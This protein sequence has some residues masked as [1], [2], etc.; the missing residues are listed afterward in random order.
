M[1]KK[2]ASHSYTPLSLQD[3]NESDKVGTTSDKLSRGQEIESP[4]SD[5]RRA[6]MSDENSSSSF[7][8]DSIDSL[9]QRRH[10]SRFRDISRFGV[11]TIFNSTY[12]NR[13]RIRYLVVTC[14]LAVVAIL[15]PLLVIKPWKHH[16]RL[17]PVT[18]DKVKAMPDEQPV[19]PIPRS[20][21]FGNEKASLTPTFQIKVQSSDNE[22]LDPTLYPILHKAINR[23]MDRI[24]TK[25]STTI[26]ETNGYPSHSQDPSSLSELVI[27]IDNALAPLEY[28]VD[29]SY[30]ININNQPGPQPNQE[31]SMVHE[32]LKRQ[33]RA[34]TKE[35]I[36]VLKAN[37]QFGIMNGLE[38]F[39]Q[40]I[41]A[42]PGSDTLVPGQAVENILEIPNVPWQIQDKPQFSHRG[43]LLD[44][45]R[46]YFPVKDI[47]RTLDAMSVVRLNVFHWHVLDQQTYPLV[48]ESFPELTAKGAQRPDYVYTQNDVATIVRHGE[49]LGIR[50]LPE[51]DSPGHAASWGRSYPNLTVCLDAQPHQKYAAEPPAGQLDPLEPF[52]Y[53]VLDSLVKEW[54]AQ[55]PDKQAHMGGDE[56]NFNCWKT[57]DRLRDYIEHANH[58]AQYENALLPALTNAA[59]E[60][61]MRRTTS[62]KQ[63]GED[64]LLEVYLN[65]TFGMFLAQ[66]KR[67]IVWE[68][69]ALEHNLA[70]PDSAIVQVWKNAANAKKVIAQGKPVILSSSEYWYLDCGAGQWLIGSQGH[71]W[72][73]FAS[74]QRLYSYSFTDQFNVEQQKM[75]YGGEVCMWAEQTDSSNLDSNLWPRSAAA[76]EVLWSGSR[77]DQENERPLMDAAK[78]LAA[79]RD[80]LVQMGVTAAPMYPSYCRHHP[81]GCLS[82]LN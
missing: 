42:T 17:A 77:D 78:R 71:S 67:P 66:G 18:N 9:P 13:Y 24:Q 27:V 3:P 64:K 55:F 28:G 65:R 79:V 61:N 52:T 47:L 53:T 72:C 51:F 44:T 25:R 80:R 7:E 4:N 19:W 82:P 54:T 50:V 60:N 76:A 8:M 49:E 81:E 6:S 35:A 34:P 15:V 75:V 29:E 16:Y 10:L 70:L 46:N 26:I 31:G 2:N 73:Q 56:I 22:P 23:C 30:S 59:P 38:T 41:V 57:S 69:L 58:R 62:G 21:S 11:G 39:T 20:F 43:I 32:E 37:T 68:E 36:A 5:H 63:S 33:K 74:W 12:W 45:S 48:S 40:L 1:S 14:I